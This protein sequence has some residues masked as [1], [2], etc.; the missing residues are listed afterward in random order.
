M[1]KLQK[2]SNSLAYEKLTLPILT[3]FFPGYT[4]AIELLPV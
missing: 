3:V 1:P 4:D 2:I